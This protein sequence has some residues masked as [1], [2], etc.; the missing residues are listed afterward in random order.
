MIITYVKNG[1]L[2]EINDT[3]VTLVRGKAGKNTN[4]INL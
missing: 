2:Q 3:F 4:C 1:K